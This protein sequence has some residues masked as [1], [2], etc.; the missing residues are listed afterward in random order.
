MVGVLGKWLGDHLPA[1]SPGY[2][3]RQVRPSLKRAVSFF[4]G[5][6]GQLG[7]FPS[8]AMLSP[9]TDKASGISAL[10]MNSLWGVLE[11]LAR[12]AFFSE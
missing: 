12:F 7:Q 11:R 1:S 4:L 3:A 8:A 10:G 6:S 2:L 5:L 9:S